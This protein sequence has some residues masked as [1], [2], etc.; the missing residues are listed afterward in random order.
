MNSET[1][2]LNEDQIFTVGFALDF[3]D[4]EVEYLLLLR[5]HQATTNK[6]RKDFLFQ[7]ISALQKRHNLSL[8]TAKSAPTDFSDDMRYLMDYQVL[9]V[10]AALSIKS[11]QKNPSILSSLLGMDHLR[12]KE[13]LTLLNRTGRIEY[14][15]K[16]GEVKKLLTARIHYGKDHPLTRT[17]QLV[18]KTALNQLSFTKSEEKKENIFVTF[19]TD[20]AGFEQIKNKIKE[21]TSQI[22]KITFDN[23]HSGVYQMNLDFLEVFQ[24]N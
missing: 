3:L 19:T 2:Q 1:I 22:Q 9:V 12:L 14:D 20:P 15:L 18:M 13:I 16:S 4:D 8:N 11:I 6:V 21:F 23:K 5:S 7:K 24:L 10:H 17:H